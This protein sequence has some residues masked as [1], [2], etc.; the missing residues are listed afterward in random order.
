MGHHSVYMSED[1]FD[2]CLMN[3]ENILQGK[4]KQAWWDTFCQ[5]YQFIR[6]KSKHKI[7]P[8]LNHHN[9]LFAETFPA[10]KKGNL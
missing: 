3:W 7:D 8:F 2:D 9:H 5:R 4:P 1:V 10:S 6:S